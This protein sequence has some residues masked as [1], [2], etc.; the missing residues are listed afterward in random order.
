VSVSTFNGLSLLTASLTEPSIGNWTIDSE[1]RV[2]EGDETVDDDVTIDLS[3]E[4]LIGH[5]VRGAVTAN[6]WSGRVEGGSGGMRAVNPSKYYVSATVGTVLD[7]IMSDSGESLADDIDPSVL[8]QSLVPWTRAMS[9]TRR[10]VA[11][12]AENIGVV[13][14]VNRNGKIWLGDN[15]YEEPEIEYV[16]LSQGAVDSVLIAPQV[17]AVRPGDLF[18]DR[19]VSDVQTVLTRTR[20]E[21]TI[22]YQSKNGGGLLGVMGRLID[23]FVGRRLDYS[24]SYPAVVVSQAG[25]DSLEVLIDDERMR[26]EGLKNIPIRLGIPGARCEVKKGA[27]V[28]VHFDSQDPSKPFAALWD[29]EPGDVTVIE[30]GSGSDFLT[31][32]DKVISM[33]EEIISWND[34]HMHTIPAGTDAL[35]GVSGAPTA[36]APTITSMACETLRAK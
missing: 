34:G 27:R 33:L 9:E 10:Q 2:D 35:G 20:L 26:G 29:F 13:W 23:R 3:G 14:R 24:A 1:V 19:N 6:V 15:R 28:R 11:D 21:Q 22:W 25:D 36:P 31:R 8:S 5:V 16:K 30:I 7:D 17:P 4:S 12:V 32:D 18:L